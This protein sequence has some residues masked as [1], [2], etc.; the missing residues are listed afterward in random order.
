LEG[1]PEWFSPERIFRR[2]Q[3]TKLQYTAL[4]VA[5]LDGGTELD[6]L[7]EVAWWQTD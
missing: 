1:L 6:L 4:A 3:N 2:R 5:A 7:D